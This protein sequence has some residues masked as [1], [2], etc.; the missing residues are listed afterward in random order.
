MIVLFNDFL[1][2]KLSID[3]EKRI[4]LFDEDNLLAKCGLS[5]T[6]LNRGFQIYEYKE[7]EEFRYIYE[8]QLRNNETEKFIIHVRNPQMYVPYDIRKSCYEVSFSF[9]EIFQKLEVSE[10]RKHPNVDLELLHIA[11]QNYYGNKLGVK[12]TYNFIKK[13]IYSQKYASEFIDLLINRISSSLC[14]ISNYKDWFE[15]ARD[16]ARVRM[17]IDGGFI[18]RDI[19][20]LSI[21]IDKRF[22][23]WMLDN[24]KTLSANSI[25]NGPVLANRVIDYIKSKS[26]KIALIL[27]DG[28]SIE[29]WLTLYLNMDNFNYE[30]EQ[31]FIFVLI[32]SITAISRQSIFSGMLPISH[33]EPFSL[34][35]EERQWFDYWM[36]N[37]YRK[38]D[39]F[40]GK[41]LDVELSYNTRIAGIIINFIDDLM[42]GQIQGQDGMYRDIAAWAKTSEFKNLVNDLI[43]KGFN[44]YVT[45]D[46]G[47]IEAIGQG[48]PKNEG[49]LTEM[50][51][52]R[53][54]IYQDYAVT[55]KTENEY[56]VFRYPGIYMPKDYQYIICETNAAF[57]TKGKNYVC[58]GG[59]SIDEVIVPFIKIKEVDKNE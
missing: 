6:I 23:T 4:L 28:M 1:I 27:L 40:F 32:P 49:V 37:G 45:S 53:A 5:N 58:H 46:H 48:R 42:H 51:S 8:S 19:N 20:R 24:Y 34:Q 18:Q 11:H 50:T 13:E 41:G 12:G 30:I 44:V 33:S 47:N 14:K 38:E 3:Y 21:E 55:D 56:K 29:N 15:I 39:I 54:R 2:E 25:S 31:G 16:W 17:L 52:L 22:K 43:R 35:N 57:G 10:L 36:N 59:M 7:V 9:V 26:D